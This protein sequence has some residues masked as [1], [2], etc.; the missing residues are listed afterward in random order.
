MG[1]DTGT[2]HMG[3]TTLTLHTGFGIG[4]VDPRIFGGFLE[5]MGRCVYEGVFEPGSVHADED[6]FRRDV[7]AALSRLKMP[8]VRYPGGNFASGY[9]WLDGVGPAESRPT[10]R[11]LAWQ[12]VETNRFGT[13]EF[14]RLCRKLDWTPMLS[15]NLGTGT[16]QEARD[17][18]EYCNAPAGT[19]YADM[20]V[21]NGGAAPHAVPLWCLGNEMDGPWQ[22]GHVPAD[23]YAIRAQQAAKMMKDVDPRI[24]LVVCGSS[25]T[26]LPSY[27]QWDR[28]VLEYVG[29][30]ADYISLHRY[31][32]NRA[33]DTADF[34]AVTNSI[35]RQIE[36][37]DAVC[38]F[39]Q[40]KRKRPK[41]AYLCF[42]E[43][44]IWYKNMEMSG[45]GQ[46]A[47]H[48]IEETYNLEDALVV[49][50]FF[51]SFIRHA[52]V[53]KIANIA[54][55]VNVIAPIQTR[56][57]DLLLQSIF[58]VFEMYAKRR[59]GRAL[60][61]VVDGPVYEGATNGRVH[62][63][64]ASA[65][66]DGDRMHVFATNRSLT[67][68]APLRVDLADRQV[69]ALVDAEIVTGDD[70]KAENSFENPNVIVPRSFGDVRVDA[71]AAVAELAPLSVVAMTFEL[72]PR[73]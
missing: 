2:A 59:T 20:R 4:D 16:P 23:Q 71:G 28:E 27:M 21:E 51:N 53:V 34:L 13:E 41:R 6:G 57:E 67:E 9:H 22:L 62:T 73:A 14:M 15:V 24:E 25:M 65:I 72:S 33:D 30:L 68:T 36:E 60:R 17:W 43:W 3:E 45:A 47:P 31:V 29:G 8:V 63:V 7:L 37:M 38:R 50:G 56:G 10:V 40:A 70:P 58:H 69:A 42:D 12:S 35:D 46:Q 11:E 49:S 19:R 61:A 52:D 5:H 39:V 54:Q 18:V 26:V 1:P 66:L 44:N 48:L 32:D 64:D 55:V